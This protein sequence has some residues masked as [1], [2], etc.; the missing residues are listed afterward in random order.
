MTQYVE[1]FDWK[2]SEI[3]Q[4]RF[5]LEIA[6]SID[7]FT[8]RNITNISRN[9]KNTILKERTMGTEQQNGSGEILTL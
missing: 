7:E 6:F 5:S 9:E 1:L 4:I 8:K 2:K 3:S